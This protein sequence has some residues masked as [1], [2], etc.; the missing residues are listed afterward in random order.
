MSYYLT[1]SEQSQEEIVI[2]RSRFIGYASPVSTQNEATDFIQAI[3]QKHWNATHN[4]SAYILRKGGIQRYSDDG[5]P[6]GTA[7]V[8]VLE[9]IKKES[10]TDCV[11]VVTRY[12]GGALLGAGGLVRAYSNTASAVILKS[13]I[14]KMVLCSILEVE[15]DYSLYGRLPSLISEFGGEIEDSIFAEKVKLFFALPQS[16]EKD[17]R[18][19]LLDVS[20]GKCIPVN[21]GKKY[22]KLQAEI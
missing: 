13:S 7:G 5:E 16:S 19:N 18:N 10:L 12:F 8:P 4:V 21:K 22:A 14:V 15:S 1:L 6:Q 11:I 2:K 20:L 17:F 9:V 3:K